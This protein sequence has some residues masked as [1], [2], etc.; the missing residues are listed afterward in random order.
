LNSELT[1]SIDTEDFEK[2]I[3][4]AE[5]AKRG[6]KDAE[7]LRRHLEAAPTPFIAGAFM[8]GVYDDWAEELR[9]YYSEQHFR[10]LSGLAKLSFTEKAGQTR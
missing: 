5:N 1:Y 3:G 9:T 2:H 10:V 6:K 8:S 7:G 4:D